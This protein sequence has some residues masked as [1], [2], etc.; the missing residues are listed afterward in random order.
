[1]FPLAAAEIR[2]VVGKSKHDDLE[3]AFIAAYAKLAE[4]IDL[5]FLRSFLESEN[6]DS[7]IVVACHLIQ[8]NQFSG[9]GALEASG[10]QTSLVLRM[11]SEIEMR[12][13]LGLVPLL[14]GQ[15][16]NGKSNG[17]I[18][19]NHFI[20]ALK[21]KRALFGITGCEFP[22]DVEVSKKA[23]TEARSESRERRIE[24]ISKLAPAVEKPFKAE[25]IGTPEKSLLRLTNVSHLPTIIASRP[26][27][28]SQS[29]PGRSAGGGPGKAS[30]AKY[31]LIAPGGFL[32]FPFKI[33]KRLILFPE[34]Q[35]SITLH[36][37]DNGGESGSRAWIGIVEVGFGEG[38]KENRQEKKVEELW[39]N[40]N[41][42]EIGQTINDERVGDWEFFNEEGDRIRKVDYS[43]GGTAES[44][45]EH[46]SNKGA[47]IRKKK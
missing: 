20:P 9:F 23:W 21:A 37:L 29:A 14:I 36:F 39:P 5:K 6:V 33:E 22:F 13:D 2:E 44:N 34:D 25:L 18:G 11:I 3:P 28:T 41:L 26:S 12:K 43:N 16:E 4:E 47:G 32:E 30:G 7:Q 24:M 8:Q 31:Q 10:G 15:L 42:K 46:P 17:Y 40:G 38:W 19:N 45:P 27:H 1:M 35:R